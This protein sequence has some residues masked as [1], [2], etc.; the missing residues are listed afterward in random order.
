MRR[1]KKISGLNE[2]R[3][4]LSGDLRIL[5]T[6]NNSLQEEKNKIKN[7]LKNNG[8]LAMQ[9]VSP[10]FCLVSHLEILIV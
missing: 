6:L 9:T 7:K 2:I 1:E 8:N 3:C 5:T 4:L 10:I